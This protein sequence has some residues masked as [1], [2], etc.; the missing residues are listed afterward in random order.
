MYGNGNKKH[1]PP[2]GIVDDITDLGATTAT[3]IENTEGPMYG[4]EQPAP[5]IKQPDN[6]IGGF[7][8]QTKKK[9]GT[10]R[11]SMIGEF[12][13]EAGPTGSG[14]ISEPGSFVHAQTTRGVVSDYDAPKTVVRN[15]YFGNI[16]EPRKYP[17]YGFGDEF[18]V[19]PPTKG[20][21]AETL[22]SNP[23]TAQTDIQ[24]TDFLGL[25]IY[26]NDND[27]GKGPGWDPILHP[28]HPK[29]R[30][31]DYASVFGNFY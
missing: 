14:Y 24:E 23:Q 21:A 5:N 25:G 16:A 13:F 6:I 31:N 28:K 8:V 1:A 2:P 22:T 11:Q 15:K 19:A 30:T 26:V 4:K 3:G 12:E 9:D 7:E 29:T 20:I 27:Y 17:V 10:P 18:S